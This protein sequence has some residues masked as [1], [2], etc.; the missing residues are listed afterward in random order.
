MRF[1]LL[2]VSLAASVIAAPA[3]AGECFTVLGQLLQS[4][5]NPSYRIWKIGTKHMLGV[6]DCSGRDESDQAIPANVQAIAGKYV[7]KRVIGDFEVCPLSASATMQR[8]CIR[9]ATHLVV[10]P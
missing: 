4:N 7:E 9:S 5:G 8:V 2:S 6:V 1:L 3:I 10:A